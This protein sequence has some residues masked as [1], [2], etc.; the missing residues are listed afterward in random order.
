M[1]RIIISLNCV[2]GALK[3]IL[4]NC[5]YNN[6]SLKIPIDKNLYF[7]SRK[8]VTAHSASWGARCIPIGWLQE[9]S[10]PSWGALIALWSLQPAENFKTKVKP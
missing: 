10:T 9:V 6:V 5:L 4:D 7:A 3:T 8:Y 1:N 2:F